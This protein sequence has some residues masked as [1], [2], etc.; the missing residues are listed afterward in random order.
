MCVALTFDDEQC[1]N[2]GVQH[3]YFNNISTGPLSG[4]SLWHRM[5]QMPV[6]T[7]MVPSL[8]THGKVPYGITDSKEVL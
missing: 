7:P 8:Q 1:L 4:Y 3:K 5:I 2:I 6:L